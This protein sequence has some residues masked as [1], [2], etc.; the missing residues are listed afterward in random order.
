MS[1]T[2]SSAD[3]GITVIEYSGVT[4]IDASAQATTTST[5]AV[6]LNTTQTDMFVCGWGNETYGDDIINSETLIRQ[7]VAGFGGA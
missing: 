3:A 2:G 6:V 5:L 7:L 1:V 4:G